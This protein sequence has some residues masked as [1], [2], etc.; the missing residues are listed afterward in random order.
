MQKLESDFTIMI[1]EKCW[2]DYVRRGT[3]GMER[4]EVIEIVQRIENDLVNIIAEINGLNVCQGPWSREYLMNW[5][6][7]YEEAIEACRRFLSF[8]KCEHCLFNK[9]WSLNLD[10][11]AF[12][13]DN[14]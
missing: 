14:Y 6:D 4:L 3:F 8:D 11:Y 9:L 13:L 10:H 1:N 2:K 7:K 12:A 5:R